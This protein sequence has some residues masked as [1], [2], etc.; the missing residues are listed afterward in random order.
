MTCPATASGGAMIVSPGLQV[1]MNEYRLASAPEPT[2]TSAYAG[3]EDPRRQHR[4]RAPRSARSPRGRSRT[5]R[6]GSRATAATR[7]PRHQ[8]L[9]ARVHDVG[10]RVEVDAGD[11]VDAVVLVR[12][13]LDLRLQSRAGQACRGDVA[14]AVGHGRGQPGARCDGPGHGDVRRTRA[15]LPA[16][17]APLREVRPLGAERRVVAVAG[18]E[19]GVVG[20]P[21]EDLGLD[22]VDELLRTRWR[23]RRCCRRRRGR[24]SRR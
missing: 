20:Q 13:A 17:L 15:D 18:V 23:R 4:P 11:V 9:G 7:G 21:V 5:C 19:P 22:L 8:R 12:E 1:A 16:A 24:A 10:R 2:R 6:R 3:A 14:D